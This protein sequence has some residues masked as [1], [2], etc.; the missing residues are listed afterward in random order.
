MSSIRVKAV[1]VL[2]HGDAYL[3]E[4][5]VDPASGYTF[6]R[7]VGGS[8]EFGE[9]A[10]AAVRREWREELALALPELALA[11]VLEN[12]FT[13][14]GRPGHEIVF[15]YLGSATPAI[16]SLPSGHTTI[17]ADGTLHRIEWIHLPA[18][19]S[20]DLPLVPGGCSPCFAP[21][22]RR[23][24]SSPPADCGNMMY[25]SGALPRPFVKPS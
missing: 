20:T 12:N 22:H 23:Q 14:A 7:A 13:Y 19:P 16:A 15:V 25:T 24:M 8:L 4:C 1:A 2:R 17:D 10:E 11:G 6:Y 21:R 3:V 18:A 5:G 9:G